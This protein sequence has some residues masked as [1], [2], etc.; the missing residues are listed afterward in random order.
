MKLLPSPGPERSRLLLMIAALVVMAAAYYKWGGGPELV[1]PH[2]HRAGRDPTRAGAAARQ[3]RE[4][5]RTDE[6]SSAVDA[7][8]L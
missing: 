4:P 5:L 6:P 1:I 8:C 3:G 7:A 2:V